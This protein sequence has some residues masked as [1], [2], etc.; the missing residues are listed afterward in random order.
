[1][2]TVSDKVCLGSLT[3]CFN[4]VNPFDPR[5]PG[6]PRLIV[7]IE[8]IEYLRRLQFSWTK[9]AA[10]LGI[11]RS[12]LYCRL[13]EEGVD[14]TCTYSDISNHDLDRAVESIKY[15]HPND[16][17]RL[18]IGH[19]HC[20]GIIVPRSRVRASIHRVDPVNTA[21]RRSI[22]I[23]KR[24]YCVDG[25]NSL[26]HIDGLHKLIKW[27]FVI[28]G[29]VDG[30]SQTIVYLR[31]ST[32]NRASTVMASF[33]DAV[34]K[35]GL[36]DRVRSDLGGENSEV[37]RYMLEQ[38]CLE[39]AILVGS[40]THNQRIERMW[41]DVHRCI[42][43]LYAD[44]FREMEDD[45]KLSCLNEIDLYCLHAVFLPRINSAI[46]SFVECWNNYPLSTSYNLTPNQMFIEGA[47][48]RNMAPV[49]PSPT[50]LTSNI[51][52]PTPSDIVVVP[53]STFHPCNNLEQELQQ[54][55]MLRVT[56]DFGYS[57][58]RNVCR[59]VGRHLQ[60]CNRCT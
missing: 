39:S 32:N 43:V 7:D 60:L 48:R 24:V 22:T 27:R 56:E 50:H 52:A 35:Y 42:C 46:D 40:S 21:I 30:Y 28:H 1:M 5:S 14:L 26:W 17:E 44:L 49:L 59:I 9:V 18:M 37:W 8:E 57:V 41:R 25:P 15:T 33:S 3:L 55:D 34:I 20:L 36:P 13:E 4:V 11:S 51:Q 53:R 16:G 19:L 12:T 2:Y 31:C 54:V 45:G 38:H 23:R 58:Y 47:L 6:R 10:I 29:A